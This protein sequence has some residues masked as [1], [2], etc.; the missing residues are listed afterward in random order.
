MKKKLKYYKDKAWKAFSEYIRL[1]D[2]LKT[3]GTPNEGICITCG[4]RIPFKGS[5]AGHFISSRC[6]S[7][8]FEEDLTFL[9]CYHCNVGLMGNYVPF[10]LKM[11]ELHSKKWVEEKQQLKHQTLK[12]NSIDYMEIEAKY[13]QKFKDLM[14]KYLA[15][16]TV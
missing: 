6:N 11:I 7:V 13:K 2:C 9:Q 4:N 5:N 14:N 1:R 10:T 16:L 8:L 12:R 3:T 15:R